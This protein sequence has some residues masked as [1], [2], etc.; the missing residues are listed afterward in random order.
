MGTS[1]SFRGAGTTPNAVSMK[2]KLPSKE[3]S[4]HGP[5]TWAEERQTRSQEGQQG[6]EPRIARLRESNPDLRERN[7]GSGDGCP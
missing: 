2:E 6:M 1:P 7:H 3:A 4:I 5:C